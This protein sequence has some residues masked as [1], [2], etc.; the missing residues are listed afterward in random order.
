VVGKIVHS[1]RETAR[2]RLYIVSSLH[3][4]PKIDYVHSRV[5]SMILYNL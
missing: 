2:P 5:Y 4:E 3:G 1:L